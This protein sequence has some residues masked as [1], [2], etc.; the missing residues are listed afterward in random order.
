MSGNP[1]NQPLQLSL[2]LCLCLGLCLSLAVAKHLAAGIDADGDNSLVHHQ[3]QQHLHQQHQPHQHQHSAAT[4]HRRRLQRDSRAKDLAQQCESVKSYF[5]SIDIRSSGVFNEKGA[6]CGGSCCSNATELELRHKAAGKFE[7]LLHHHTSSLRGILETTASQ[8]QSHVVELAEQSENKTLNVFSQVYR[9]MEPLSRML[10]QQLYTE[11]INHLKY[12]SNYSSNNGQGNS[13]LN[14]QSSLES[15]LHKFFENLFPVAYHQAVHLTKDNYGELHDDYTNCLK[16]NYDD[17]QPFGQIPKE[18]QTNLVHSVHMSNVFMSALLQSA[19]VLSETDALYG[20]QLTETCKLHLLKM[21]YCPNCNGHTEHKRPKVCYSYCM[22][23]MRG[24]SAQYSGLLDGPWASVVEGLDNLVA[25]HIRSESGIM[26][27]IKQLDTKLS[28]A[29][30]RAMENGPELEKKVKKTCGTPNLLPSLTAAE[31]QPLQQHV[32]IKWA[33]SPE[34]SILHFLSTIQ[35]S[36]DFFT[37]IVYNFCDEDYTQSNDHLCWTGDRIGDYTQLLIMP[38]EDRQ[39][40]NPEVP[41]ENQSQLTKLNELVDKLQKI[42]KTIGVTAPVSNNHDIQSDMGHEGSGG[43]GGGGVG[44][45]GGHISDDEEEYSSMHGSGD[46]SG[47]GPISHTDD[48]LGS[49]PNTFDGESRDN[50]KGA[51]SA[52]T[53]TATSLLLTLVTLYSSCS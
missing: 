36:K 26:N 42:R 25:G 1:F 12:T 38:G 17:L 7:Q 47:D 23:V 27:T 16:H 30:M 33:M 28:E 5:E 48:P 49:T 2:C 10:I 52:L 3:Q 13:I 15:A 35:K 34:A 14:S 37:N 39:R 44:S 53:A 20:K 24:C 4:H 51:S 8:F 21:H 11:I 18:I 50:S 41:W 46:G 45:V 29:I 19:K 32:S 43:G 22:N 31:T 9:R 40:Y 6:T